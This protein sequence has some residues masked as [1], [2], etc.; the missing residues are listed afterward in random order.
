[1]RRRFRVLWVGRTKERYI[2]EGIEGYLKKLKP[3][4]EIEVVQ[5]RE[6]SM[7]NRARGM[8]MEEERILRSAGSFILFKESG[9]KM[10]SIE[11]AEYLNNRQAATFVIGGAYGVTHAVEN[12][13]SEV[14]SL[15]PMTFTHE[16]VRLI[17]L[18]QLFRG[19][20][21]I[22]GMRYHH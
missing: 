22:K 19:M 15:S 20:T 2:A 1:M 9:T 10:D 17:F 8:R 18:E 7:K 4:S 14:I 5:I 16:M 21:I 12:A 6:G 11:F 13:A 3:L